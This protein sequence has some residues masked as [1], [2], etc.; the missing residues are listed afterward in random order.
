[1]PGDMVCYRYISVNTL[2][3]GDD[4]GDDYY[5]MMMMTVIIIIIII[6]IIITSENF[7][8]FSL[9]ELRKLNLK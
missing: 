8:V 3:E 5:I 7:F 9:G 4:N 2:H 6:I 1:M